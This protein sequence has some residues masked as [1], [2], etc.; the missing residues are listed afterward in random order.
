MACRWHFERGDGGIGELKIYV[1]NSTLSAL[2]AIACI[3]T[4]SFLCSAENQLYSKISVKLNKKTLEAETK[5]I[6]KIFL[7]NMYIYTTR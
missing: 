4:V 7:H 5:S 3:L 6:N 1:A 2:F